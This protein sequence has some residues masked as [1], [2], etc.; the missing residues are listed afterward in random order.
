MRRRTYYGCLALLAGA[1]VAFA[2]LVWERY[3]PPAPWTENERKL[4]SS[5]WLERLPPLP[6][7]PTNA[8]ADDPRAAVL[9][10]RL[11][12]DPRLSAN[13]RI[14]C[15][16]CHQPV[17]RFTDGLPRA[18]AIG[19]TARNTQ[20]I[21]GSAYSPWLYWDGRKDSQWSQALA[22]LEAQAEHG[23]TRGEVVELLRDDPDYRRRYESL[24]G[25]MPGAG[26]PAESC[27]ANAGKALAAYERLL[28][29]GP[30]RF[31]SYVAHLE[32]GG[33]PLEQSLL[34]TREIRGLRLFIGAA[35]CI[36]CHNGPLFTNH[37]F[38][39]TGLLAPPGELPERGRSDGLR[40]L[41]DDPFNCAGPHSDDPARRCPEL[42]FARADST[43]LGATRTPSLR[44]LAGTAPF[45]S[46]G[47]FGT[48]S[49]VLAHYN[50]APPA[51]IGHNET[52]PLGLAAWELEDLE[53]FLL[54]LDAP[55]AAPPA[56]LK[57]PARP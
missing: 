1:W 16:H 21:V 43:L 17:R 6:T 33:D 27:F 35:Q 41:R 53:A 19:T 50:A 47:Q 10:Q 7:D 20:S 5:L 29:P 34:T 57:P 44:N 23:L 3:A 31:D 52:K 26:E 28:K 39:N 22:P 24:F 56:L 15:A 45:Q 30:S 36:N 37:E 11:F 25:P 13:G 4:L 18:I 9:G 51:M 49:E 32:A 2:Y 40:A 54:T 14:A 55:V 8:V 12:F 48:L 42:E 38:H 46:K